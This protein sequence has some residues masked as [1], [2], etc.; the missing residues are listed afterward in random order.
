M[1]MKFD[2]VYVNCHGLTQS[3]SSIKFD[4]VYDYIAINISGVIINLY[5]QLI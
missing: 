3:S 2:I 5:I 1:F 4:I